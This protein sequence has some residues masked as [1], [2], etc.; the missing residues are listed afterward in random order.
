MTVVTGFIFGK[1]RVALAVGTQTLDIYLLDIHR[2]LTLETLALA[3]H[4][5]VLGDVGTAG[6]NDIC[7]GLAYTR[8]SVYIA[9]M[10]TGTLLCDHLTTESVLANDAVAARQVKDQLRALNG[11][12]GRRR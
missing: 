4:R 8:R 1:V 7:R 6:E 5:A 12:L 10:N 11:Q 9:A 2:A 3:K